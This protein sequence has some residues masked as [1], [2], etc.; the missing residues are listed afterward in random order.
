LEARSPQNFLGGRRASMVN[1]V[2]HLVTI[3][4]LD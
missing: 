4:G 3:P 2:L 1:P